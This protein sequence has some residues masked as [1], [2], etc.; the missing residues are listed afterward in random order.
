MGA[1]QSLQ[2]KTLIDTEFSKRGNC[3]PKTPKKPLLGGPVLACLGCHKIPQN[4]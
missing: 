4:G 2:V 1:F 3:G